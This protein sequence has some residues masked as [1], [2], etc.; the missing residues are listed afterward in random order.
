MFAERSCDLF[1][2]GIEFGSISMSDSQSTTLA[3]TQILSVEYIAVK[4]CAESHCPQRMNL[5]LCYTGKHYTG[6]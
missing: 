5:N 4:F 1:K 2:L 6:I 3:E